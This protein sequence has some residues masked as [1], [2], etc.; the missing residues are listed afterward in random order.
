MDIKCSTID[1]YLDN[2][3]NYNNSNIFYLLDLSNMN[4]IG[5]Y[6]F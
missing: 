3:L 4:K 2:F 5:A 1:I 6:E